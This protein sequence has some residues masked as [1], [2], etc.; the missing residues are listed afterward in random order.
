MHEMGV[1]DVLAED[2]AGEKAVYDFVR[3]HSKRGRAWQG[4]DRVR[5]DVFGV[6]KESLE[7]TADI[8]VETALGLEDSD[9]R[10]MDR[11]ARAQITRESN[12]T[13]SNAGLK[14]GS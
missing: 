9:M 10:I 1:V 5:Q 3:N 12:G 6:T 11:L 14:S 7:R 8:W 13:G 4:I 2:G